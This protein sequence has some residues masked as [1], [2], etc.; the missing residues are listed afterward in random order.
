MKT[1]FLFK[2]L[3]PLI[4]CPGQGQ[5]P[6]SQTAPNLT[7]PHWT[8]LS[9][10]ISRLILPI[11]LLIKKTK[12]LCHI[13]KLSGEIFQ[14]LSKTVVCLLLHPDSWKQMTNLLFEVFALWAYSTTPTTAIQVLSPCKYILYYTQVRQGVGFFKINIY[15]DRTVELLKKKTQW[16]WRELKCI[17]S[18]ITKSYR[19]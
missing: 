15:L 18:E 11:W 2:N 3:I 1:I 4:L 13:Q 17:S 10:F 12:N 7:P 9:L 6:Q 5:V 19:N 8:L 14:A 16:E